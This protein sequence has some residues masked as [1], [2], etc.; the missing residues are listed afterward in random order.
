MTSI[1]QEALKRSVLQLLTSKGGNTELQL[2][3]RFHL[4]ALLVRQLLHVLNL[5]RILRAVLV[6]LN[7]IAC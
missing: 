1:F 2:G 3:F 7:K 6:E 5:H 4:L